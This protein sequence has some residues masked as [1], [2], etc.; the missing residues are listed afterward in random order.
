[1]RDKLRKILQKLWRDKNN[2]NVGSRLVDEGIT[3][4]L[5]AGYVK[6]DEIEVDIN[7]LGDEIFQFLFDRKL[8]HLYRFKCKCV[9]GC[10]ECDGTGYILNDLGMALHNLSHTISTRIGEIIR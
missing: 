7:K 8:S 2:R 3:A 10:M 1:M 9:D 6:K 4:I 5:N